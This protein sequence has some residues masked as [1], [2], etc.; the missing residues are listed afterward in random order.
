VIGA[1]KHRSTAP[2]AGEQQRPRAA[3]ALAE[4]RQ[5]FAEILV[6]GSGISTGSFVGSQDPVDKKIAPSMGLGVFVHRDPEVQPVLVC[7][8]L[9]LAAVPHRP[10][11]RDAAIRTSAR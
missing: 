8:L 11:D 7:G 6:G 9:D 5:Q 2:V 1:G 10:H 3:A 4:L